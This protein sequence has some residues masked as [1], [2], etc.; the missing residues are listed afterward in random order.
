MPEEKYQLYDLLRLF[1]RGRLSREETP[2]EREEADDRLR[3]W[4]LETAVAAGRWYKPE[5][6]A[7][8]PSWQGPVPL[9][10]AEQARAWLQ[11]EA[12]AWLAALRGAADRGEHARFV[13]VARAM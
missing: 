6:G 7:P 2:A 8:P 12:P 4:L 9:E 3:T 5:Y 1:A 10:S 11:D 13:D